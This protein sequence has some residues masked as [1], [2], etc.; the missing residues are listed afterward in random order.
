MKTYEEEYRE[1]VE[2]CKK[3]Y[4]DAEKRI[5][6]LPK[7]G[8]FDDRGEPILREVTQEWNRK[9]RELKTKYGK[10]LK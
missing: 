10:P 1:L 2:D 6:Q 9:L 8:G 4:A 3:A 7:I 5:A